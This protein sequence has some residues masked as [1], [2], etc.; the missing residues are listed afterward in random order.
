M[1]S[2]PEYPSKVQALV[3]LQQ[4]SQWVNFIFVSRGKSI[5]KPPINPHVSALLAGKERLADT[6]NPATWADYQTAVARWKSSQTYKGI[7][8]VFTAEDPFC[9]IDL[10]HC[11][12]PTTGTIAP[13]AH[14]IL[15][16]LNS[17]SEISAT[18]SGLHIFVQ[19]S[20]STTLAMLGMSGTTPQHKKGAVELY[21]SG[22]YFTWSGRHLQGTP[23]VIEKRQEQI[24]ALYF[25]LFCTEQAKQQPPSTPASTSQN[26]L[27]NDQELIKRAERAQGRNGHLFC[28]LWRGDLSNYTRPGSNEIDY[29]RADLALCSILA[30][31][32]QKDARR[33]DR[34]FRQS[35][36]YLPRERKEKWDRPARSGETYG[37][38]TIRLAI[39]RCSH[40]YD[41]TWRP[42]GWID[43]TQIPS[44]QQH[45]SAQHA[46]KLLRPQNIDERGAC[47]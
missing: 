39:S 11:I 34:L 36:L 13:W 14:A 35:A 15:K 28:Q 18:G 9:G 24:N 19:A 21:D 47:S 38:G 7:G 44:D 32:T 12:D 29:S 2:I 17:Y 10:D 23:T 16:R 27:P 22:R 45:P 8:F 20:L 46:R 42:P 41:P 4:Y 43:F 26:M 37:E 1:C 31:W 6:R 25:E 33:I 40:I 3:Q 30:Y 5:T